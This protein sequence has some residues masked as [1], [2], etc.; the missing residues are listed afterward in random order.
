MVAIATTVTTA[1]TPRRGIIP[2]P[3]ITPPEEN[4]RSNPERSNTAHPPP[5]RGGLAAT[6]RSGTR[7]TSSAT[8]SALADAVV[9]VEATVT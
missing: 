9:V 3:P 6:Q 8:A 5:T 2:A 7:W 4:P 1:R